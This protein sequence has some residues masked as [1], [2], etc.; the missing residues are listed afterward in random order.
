MNT[1]IASAVQSPFSPNLG[2]DFCHTRLSEAA[3]IR[4][5]LTSSLL[6]ISKIPV[7][8]FNLQIFQ[9]LVSVI[10]IWSHLYQ[11]TCSWLCYFSSNLLNSYLTAAYLSFSL[12]CL[13]FLHN[14]V[15]PIFSSYVFFNSC[16]ISKR[17]RNILC[18]RAHLSKKTD[19]DEKLMLK[20]KWTWW[21]G[22]GNSFLLNP[23]CFFRDQHIYS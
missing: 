23:Y 16:Y 17:N 2:S 11:F 15:F 8:I 10:N 9:S 18:S 4:T 6:T 19:S 5:S 22:Q 14:K 7:V 12:T 1:W 20:V 3:M 21:H 13:S